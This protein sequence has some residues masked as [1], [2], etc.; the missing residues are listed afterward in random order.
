MRHVPASHRPRVYS[1]HQQLPSVGRPPETAGPVHLLGGQELGEPVGHVLALWLSHRLI[2]GAIGGDD[3]KRPR[4]P[5]IRCALPSGQDA[6]RPPVPA[7]QLAHSRAVEVGQI[8]HE[9][10]PGQR[11]RRDPHRLV[12]RKGHHTRRGLPGALPARPL[13]WREVLLA[14]R[15]QDLRVGD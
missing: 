6:D 1:G 9:Q 10:P 12:G 8:G 2:T 13:F 15:E 11:E 3:A 7:P 4:L 14:P 5:R